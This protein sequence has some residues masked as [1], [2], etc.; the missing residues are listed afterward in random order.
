[1]EARFAS[2][3]E[4]GRYI[5]VPDLAE[6]YMAD[7]LKRPKLL[8]RSRRWFPAATARPERLPRASCPSSASPSFRSIARSTTP[9]RRIIRTPKI[10]ACCTRRAMR[11]RARRRSRPR[12]RRRRRPLR[13]GRQRGRRDLRRQGRRDARPRHRRAQ[14]GR[15][16]RR[17]REIDRAIPHRSRAE[18]ARRQ[19]LVLEDR[20]LL[21]QALQPRDR[22]AGRLREVGAFLL[23]PAARPGL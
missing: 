22:R 9:S 11:A 17:R 23:Q 8:G 14:Q 21:H 19:N 2:H 15:A 7:L 20:P 16:V 4:G 18:R 10:S 5:F 3:A 12:L 6:R 13:R 1:M